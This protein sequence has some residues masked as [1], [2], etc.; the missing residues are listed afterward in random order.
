MCAKHG[1]LKS[2]AKLRRPRRS[3]PP[4]DLTNT[5]VLNDKGVRAD[6]RLE[7]IADGP[8]R[9]GPSLGPAIA[10]T[11]ESFDN[12]ETVHRI[13]AP[14][15]RYPDT[16]ARVCQDKFP[17]VVRENRGPGMEVRAAGHLAVRDRGHG[18]VIA[19]RVGFVS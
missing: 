8:I 9:K 14:G 6:V 18:N 4:S 3:H 13:A 19:F 7:A 17:G 16:N 1:E 11:A 2:I 5:D 10:R 15:A 12:A